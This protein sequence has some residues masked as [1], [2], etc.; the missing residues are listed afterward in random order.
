MNSENRIRKITSDMGNQSLSVSRRMF[1]AGA[2]GAALALG[3]PPLV[4]AAGTELRVGTY[5]GSWQKAIEDFIAPAITS[6]GDTINYV[7]GSAEDNLAKVIASKRQGQVP[8]DV[9]DGTAYFYDD[10]FNS[11]YLAEID[12]SKLTNTKNMP[13]GIFD[14]AQ[15]VVEWT[16][17]CI[18]YNPDK[19]AEAGISP[20]QTYADLAN[21]KF[22][23]RV[24]FPNVGHPQH[25]AAVIGLARANGGDESNL[26]MVPELVKEMAPSY[27]YSG[28]TELSTRFASGDIWAAPWGAGWAVRMKRGGIPAA[29]SYP[30][31]GDKK[32]GLWPNIKWMIAGTTNGDLVHKYIDEWLGVEGAAKFCEAT[33]TVP[34]NPKA[35][36]LMSESE[37][38]REMLL[39]SDEEIA[40]AYRVDWASF[41][42]DAWR[43]VWLRTVQN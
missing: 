16:P 40:N 21:P 1:L 3:M 7:I 38:N 30:P 33:G 34:T 20:P 17:D 32:G 41:D 36:K 14:K 12:Y 4:R 43:D 42:I 29:V 39:L 13:D 10:A 22:A 37:Q 31:I 15:V 27:F 11:G 8:F 23:G 2:G 18:V 9:M 5:G 24:A 19:L 6:D 26:S 25:W 35:R 28:S